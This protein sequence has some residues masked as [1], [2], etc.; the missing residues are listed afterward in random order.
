MKFFVVLLL[1]ISVSWVFLCKWVY[2]RDESLAKLEAHLRAGK[3]DYASSETA[4]LFALIKYRYCRKLLCIRYSTKRESFIGTFLYNLTNER[5]RKNG[6]QLSMGN[7]KSFST[8]D[9]ERFPIEKLR[10]IDSLWIRYSQGRFGFSIQAA[11][12]KNYGKTVNRSLRN[13][14]FRNRSLPGTHWMNFN[15]VS[16]WDDVDYFYYLA[17]NEEDVLRELG[18]LGRSISTTPISEEEPDMLPGHF[19]SSRQLDMV[20]HPPGMFPNDLG[21]CGFIASM[22]SLFIWRKLLR[23]SAFD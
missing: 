13:D 19:L 4:T 16:D 14:R 21:K 15:D 3:W 22:L 9:I 10:E 20:P 1:L 17:K 11:I 8:E 12:Y 18:W 2:D 7:P 23:G 6:I 5:H